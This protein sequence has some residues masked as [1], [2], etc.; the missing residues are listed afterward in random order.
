MPPHAGVR[1]AVCEM[2]QAIGAASCKHRAL[3]ISSM[4]QN[5]FIFCGL[6]TAKGLKK[7][8]KWEEAAGAVLWLTVA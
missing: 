5:G 6:L 7:H 8:Q 1:S 3:S 4:G 2:W